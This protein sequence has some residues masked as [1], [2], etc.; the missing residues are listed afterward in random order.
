MSKPAIKWPLFGSKSD[1]NSLALWYPSFNK[2][3]FG[4]VA[5]FTIYLLHCQSNLNTTIHQKSLYKS[6]K[7]IRNGRIPQSSDLYA[8]FNCSFY[9]FL[10][11]C[12]FFHNVFSSNSKTLNHKKLLSVSRIPQSIGPS[13]SKSDLKIPILCTH[14]Y[15]VVMSHSNSLSFTMLPFQRQESI[16]MALQTFEM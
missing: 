13:C 7:S 4:C 15:L 14:L 12:C 1:L 2:F 10:S 16:K 5:P 11:L 9:K 8:Y 3:L 6:W